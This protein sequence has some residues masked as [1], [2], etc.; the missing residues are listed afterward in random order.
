MKKIKTIVALLIT[1][2]IYAQKKD[3]YYWFG[4]TKEKILLTDDNTK[5]YIVYKKEITKKDFDQVAEASEKVKTENG[6]YY[7]VSSIVTQRKDTIN[8]DFIE[9]E[10]GSKIFGKTGK[11]TLTTDKIYIKLK[12]VKDRIL[13]ENTIAKYKIQI[14]HQ[15]EYL[16]EWYVLV[17]NKNSLGN[18]ISIA[19]ELYETGLFQM[20]EPEFLSETTSNCN[21]NPLF[22]SQWGA[23]NTGQNGGTSGI[24]INLCDAHQI[25]KGIPN[26]IVA[27]IDEGVVTNNPDL[28]NVSPVFY[29]CHNNTNSNPIYGHHGTACAGII[30]AND[31]NY[32]IIGVAPNSTIMSI[33][34]HYGSSNT[35]ETSYEKIA[36]GF[37]FASNAGASVISS[38]WGQEGGWNSLLVDAMSKVFYHGRG[39]LGTVIV[40]SAG[41]DDA[42]NNRYGDPVS[43]PGNALAGILTV[44]A[45]SQCGQRKTPSSCDGENWGSNF[46]EQLDIMAPG[47]KVPTTDRN[48]NDGY[49]NNEFR[50]D[51][52]G[53]SAA[54]PHVAGVAAL[55]LS[56]NPTLTS[57]QVNNIIESTAQKIGAYSYA[58]TPNRTNGTWNIEMGYGLLDAHAALL[59]TPMPCTSATQYNNPSL[60]TTATVSN[61]IINAQ[62][63]VVQP[64]GNLTLDHTSGYTETTFGQVFEVKAGGVLEIK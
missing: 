33:T 14:D 5:S 37:I 55:I 48:G 46:G 3:G 24:D 26:V 50:M 51:F 19:N 34:L 59:A 47:V 52:N 18:S 42:D 31:N 17:C 13:L 25:T 58:T 57:A 7:Q 2:S 8:K 9:Y 29:N 43:F 45:I 22:P 60:T 35:Q 63:V 1:V 30:G 6:K 41:N 4:H 49:T 39:G 21:N 20:V 28:C 61:C 15:N 32:G 62:N 36:N 23:N 27:V 16:K 56:K 53:T 10:I 44:G 40:F 11:K 38:S 12:D 64:N 54:A